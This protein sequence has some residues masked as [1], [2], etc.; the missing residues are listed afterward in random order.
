MLSIVAFMWDTWPAGGGPTV[1]PPWRA[2]SGLSG[3]SG[4]GDIEE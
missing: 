2:L 1:T 4:G 3:Q